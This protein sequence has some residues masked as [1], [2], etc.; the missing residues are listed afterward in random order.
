MSK[1]TSKQERILKAIQLLME[2]KG[3]PPTA[4][5][6][7]ARVDLKSSSTVHRYFLTLREK[8]Y[9]DWI[10]AKPRTLRILKEA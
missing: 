5:E 8:G 10:E 2:E 9:V 3:F 7:G 6:V 4:R 1:L